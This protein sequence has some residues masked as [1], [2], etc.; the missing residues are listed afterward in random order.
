M[1]MLT[2]GSDIAISDYRHDGS[3]VY[4]RQ[5]SDAS[6]GERLDRWRLPARLA[7][8]HNR[9]NPIRTHAALLVALIGLGSLLGCAGSNR[10][11]QPTTTPARPIELTVLTYNIHHA[12]GMD[13]R[14]DLQRIA[15]VIR[16][17]GA[18]LVA[19]QEV[20]N[21]TKRA[22]GV[23][24]AAEL[25]RLTNMHAVFGPA[26]SYDGGQYGNAVL[27]RWPITSS[28][29]VPL[30]WKQGNR[31]EPRCAVSATTRLP[32]GAGPLEMISTHWDHTR[33]ES[34]R[35]AQAHALNQA[36][37]DADERSILAGDF[38]CEL[39][40]PP[41]ETLGRAWTLVSGTDPAALTCCGDRLR[42][43]IDH[44]LV[45]P[46]DRWRVI[47]HR[48]IDEPVASDH[49]PVLVKLQWRR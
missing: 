38:N 20:D 48:V 31:R 15:G 13:K 1:M 2:C 45:K 18:D 11:P 22:G 34:N 40:S 9:S 3:R 37:A 10:A 41:M 35:E 8:R 6:R 16:A 26:M 30:P 39:G 7:V 5:A 4:T 49:R 32:H 24:Q 46:S 43:K 21:G 47:E 14:L 12:Q 28:R 33:N 25:A 42:A 27:S 29:I 44:V 23:D 36:W 19:L 17:S